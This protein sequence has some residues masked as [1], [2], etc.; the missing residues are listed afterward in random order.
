MNTLDI[1]KI[2][3]VKDMMISKINVTN[4][5]IILINTCLLYLKG[6]SV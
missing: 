5:P 2:R 3:C 4:K 1:I 6:Q